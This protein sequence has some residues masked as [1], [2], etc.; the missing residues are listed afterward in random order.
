MKLKEQISQ[1][2]L[3]EL[4]KQLPHLQDK[5]ECYELSTP[6]TTQHFINY[7]KGEIYGLDHTPDRFQQ[8]FLK[9]RTPIKNF[10]LTGQDIVTAGVAAALLSGVITTTAMTGKNMMKKIMQN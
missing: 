2:L 10:Y 4:F 7:S 6:L 9:P 1:R 5:I 3:K 8:Q